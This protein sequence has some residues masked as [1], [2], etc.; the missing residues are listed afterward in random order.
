[1][2]HG[3]DVPNALP[4][5]IGNF[6]IALHA[7]AGVG[8]KQV[9]LAVLLQDIA[10]QLLDVGFAGDIHG[11]FEAADLGGHFSGVVQ[12]DIRHN[13]GLGA[14]GREPPAQSAADPV[15]TARHH[16]NF[17]LQL[18]SSIIHRQVLIVPRNGPSVRT[19]VNTARPDA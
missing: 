4:I 15:S 5:V 11:V 6:A 10:H 14:L 19:N 17:V 18:H 9:D 13:H 1:M 3:I 2:R 7:D 8:A 12:L 16:H